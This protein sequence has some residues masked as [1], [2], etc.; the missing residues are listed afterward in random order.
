MNKK[1]MLY[2]ELL[3]PEG[4]R[5]YNRSNILLLSELTEL[6][7]S[8]RAGYFNTDCE[9][10]GRVHNNYIIPEKYYKYG[11]KLDYRLRNLEKIFWVRKN[12]INRLKPDIVFISSFESISLSIG[13]AGIK[14]RT[15]LVNHNNIDELSNAIKRCF[16]R[17]LDKKH[18]Y[19]SG[20]EKYISK[21]MV[22]HLKLK[23]VIVIPACITNYQR[24]KR[25]NILK[26]NKLSRLIIF[27]PSGSN[28]IR[29]IEAL[30][31]K[32]ELL[33]KLNIFFIVKYPI[34]NV[35]SKYILA[36]PYFTEDEYEKMMCCAD[37]VYVPF[38]EGFNY[39]FSGVIHDGLSCGKHI[40]ANKNAATEYLKRS[41][42]NAIYLTEN[43]IIN[44]IHRIY[45]WLGSKMDYFKE[46]IE[47]YKKEHSHEHIAKVLREIID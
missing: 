34:R 14:T 41:Y 46:Q 30:I 22:E 15:I 45:E 39:R 28:N 42:P 31:S 36:K 44:E 9:M 35:R 10:Q 27:A 3:C 6:S 4:H 47:Q 23:R 16:Y 32:Q 12:L 18:I 7:V 11:N 5:R 37:L 38:Y 25:D 20:L 24:N 13:Y 1:R 33:K 21:Y 8:G 29:D 2:I 17:Q 40:I 43:S 26:N 19:L